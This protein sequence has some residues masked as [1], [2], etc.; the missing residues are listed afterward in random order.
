MIEI[1]SVS[2]EE[3]AN[4]L[5]QQYIDGGADEVTIGKIDDTYTLVVVTNSDDVSTETYLD[6]L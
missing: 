1:D 2:T 5:K 3:E 6:T 4:I